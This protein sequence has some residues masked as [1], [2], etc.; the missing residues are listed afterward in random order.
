MWKLTHVSFYGLN[1]MY[2]KLHFYFRS[3]TKNNGNVLSSPVNENPVEGLQCNQCNYRDV[4]ISVKCCTYISNHSLFL[5]NLILWN[6]ANTLEDL[7][8]SNLS[9][10]CYVANNTIDI[11]STCDP[12]LGQ[13]SNRTSQIP[14]RFG[15]KKIL[16]VW[17]Q[18]G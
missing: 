3:N 9:D 6:M 15:P 13:G 18:M 8:F 7:E 14:V 11:L 17:L 5:K 10:K 4:S 12:R 16:T 1:K 2:Y